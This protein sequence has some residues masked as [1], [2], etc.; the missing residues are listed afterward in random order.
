[1]RRCT[2][3]TQISSYAHVIMTKDVSSAPVNNVGAMRNKTW[4]VIGFYYQLAHALLNFKCLRGKLLFYE[5]WQL[6]YSSRL[7][8]FLITAIRGMWQLWFRGNLA[9][10]VNVLIIHRFYFILFNDDK[11]G[12]GRLARWRKWSAYVIGEATE[13]LKNELWRRWS[14]GMVGEWAVT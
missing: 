4:N 7:Y 13:G 11:L 5:V 9:I 2:E 10:P 3:M 14:D 8:F 6:S 12:H 1:M